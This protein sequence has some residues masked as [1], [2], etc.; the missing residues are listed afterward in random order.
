MGIR[1]LPELV[2]GN[3]QA[4]EKAREL[5]LLDREAGE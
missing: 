4:L 2:G 3:Q 5:G 1:R